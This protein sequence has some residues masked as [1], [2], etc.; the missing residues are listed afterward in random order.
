MAMAASLPDESSSALSAI[1]SVMVSPSASEALDSPTVAA[2]ALVVTTVSSG[3][4]SS[5]TRAV[6]IL[7]IDAIWV[8]SAAFRSK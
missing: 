4:L 1:S 7:V 6:M 2:R 8:E 5:A 3:A